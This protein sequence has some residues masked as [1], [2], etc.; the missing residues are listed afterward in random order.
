MNRIE[1]HYIQLLDAE[2]VAIESLL[3]RKNS[4]WAQGGVYL[5]LDKNLTHLYVGESAD[6]MYGRI[7]IQVTT[8]INSDIYNLFWNEW[9]QP[10]YANH[11][12]TRHSF[13]M[14]P[15]NDGYL[16]MALEMYVFY[17]LRPVINHDG[18]SGIEM[19]WQ[20]KRTAYLQS[21]EI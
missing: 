13:K 11:F 14:L 3:A 21:I 5:V 16:R 4:E 7:K 8:P 10:Q 19:Q 15:V 20:A 18:L 2:P 17:T 1:E 6:N 12:K 9:A